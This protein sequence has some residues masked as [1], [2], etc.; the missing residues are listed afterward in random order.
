MAIRLVTLPTVEQ[1]GTMPKA[2]GAIATAFIAQASKQTFLQQTCTIPAD[3]PY[4][5]ANPQDPAEPRVHMGMVEA[6]PGTQ[7]VFRL[8]LELAKI[9]GKPDKVQALLDL[10]VQEVTATGKIKQLGSSPVDPV[11]IPGI[12]VTLKM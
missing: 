9:A 8:E 11:V 6:V 2:G 1:P 12:V 3:M 10:S 7:T 5:F 4:V